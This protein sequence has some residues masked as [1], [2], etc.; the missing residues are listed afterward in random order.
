MEYF[1][2]LEENPYADFYWNVP[3]VKQGKINIVGGNAQNFRTPVKI[4][5]FMGAKYPVKDVSLVLP[6]AL[7]EKLPELPDLTFLKSTESG[8]FADEGELARVFEAADFNILIGDLS[9]NKITEKAIVGAVRDSEKPLIVT[10]DAVDAFAE[11]CSE[12]SLMREGLM[13]FGSMPQVQKI[14]KAVYYPKM[15]LLSQS[16]VQVADAL[17]KFTLSYPATIITLHA[18]QILVAKDGEVVAVPLEKSGY[19]PIMIWGGE[20]AAKIAILNLYNPNNFLKAS[21]AAIFA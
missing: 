9:R 4:A 18:G 20:M 10:R 2:K 13:I 11:E 5:E 7:K 14:F 15:L 12:E 16:L 21:V 3:E 6:D 17:H 8:S 19:S 1:K